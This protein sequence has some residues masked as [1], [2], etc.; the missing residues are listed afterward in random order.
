MVQLTDAE[1]DEYLPRYPRLRPSV[2]LTVLRN[3]KERNG[4]LDAIT[5]EHNLNTCQWV[6]DQH[7]IAK[8]LRGPSR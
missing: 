4:H 5:V 6:S 2:V 3:L 8:A 7:L 1:I